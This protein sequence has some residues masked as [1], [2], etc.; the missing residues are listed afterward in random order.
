MKSLL[1]VS[2]GHRSASGQGE[3]QRRLQNGP[4]SPPPVAPVALTGRGGDLDVIRAFLAEVPARGRALLLSG[5]LG[6]GKSALLDAADEAASAAGVRILRAAGTESEEVPFSGLNQILLPLRSEFW[7]L[8][9]VHRNALKVALGLAEGPP[10]DQLVVSNAALTLL[11]EAAAVRRL[12]MIVDDLP[13][14]DQ[15]S[16]LV[17]GF[18]IRRLTGSRVWFLAAARSGMSSFAERDM[19]GHEVRPLDD[20]AA[21]VLVAARF[22]DLAPQVRRRVVAEAQGNPLALLELPTALSDRQRSGLAALRAVLPLSPALRALFASRVTVLPAATRYL[23]LLAVLEGTGRLSVLQ[24]AAAQRCE[25]DALTQAEQA[26]LVYVGQDTGRVAFR[27]PL[28]RSA[29]MELSASSDV[30]RAHRALAAQLADQPGRR[31]WHL[32]EAAVG[33]DEHVAGLLDK[34]ARQMLGRGAGADAV[35]ALMRAAQ[36]SPPGSGRSLRLAEAAYLG[37]TVT[38]DLPQVARLLAEERG[39]T[40]A[41]GGSRHAAVAHAH[42]LLN[43]DGDIDSVHR[44]LAGVLKAAPGTSDTALVAGPSDTCDTT[45]VAVLQTLL[46]VCSWGGR[47]ELW[48]SFDAAMAK[49]G[50]DVAPGLRL[51]ARTYA[52]PARSAPSALDQLDAAIDDL[53]GETD[54]WRALTLSAAASRTDRLA[55][56]RESLQRVVRDS[57]DGGA[58]LPA[59]TALTLLCFDSFARGG[60]D[61]AQRQ[62]QECLRACQ[63]HGYPSR[64]WMAREGLAILAAARGDH[65]TV[66]ALTSDMMQWALPRGIGQAQMAAHHAGSLAALGQLDFEEAYR[67]AAAISPPGILAPGVPHALSVAMD[68]VE[69]AVRTGR[70]HE[71]AAHVTAMREAGIARISPRLAMLAHASAAMIAPEP[72]ATQLFEQALGVPGAG[73][74]PF[75]FAR[76]QLAYGEHLHRIR[77]TALARVHLG[78]A[79]AT[80]RTLGARP[81]TDRAGNE[82]RATGLAT[83][84][85]E[86]AGSVTLTAQEHEIATLAAGGLT[87]KQIGQ[88]LYLSHRTVGCHLSRLYT[89]L[90]ISTRAALRDALTAMDPGPNPRLSAGSGPPKLRSA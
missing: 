25:I 88:R 18:V 85:A 65:E 32:A 38:G 69:A 27:H 67:E 29:V 31:A 14:V 20:G 51:F 68:L 87:N 22:P 30:R 52:D 10:C 72:Q 58:A 42:V 54:Q 9:A 21:A 5:E 39:G 16:A 80:F 26:G 7:R 56:C 13:W 76:V 19:P 41:P 43:T 11:C 33:P 17:L 23:L 55:G 74:W 40:P 73:R 49:L 1:E 15:A 37:A 83:A 57:Q 53:P 36:L 81:W 84:R 8:S 59:I 90:G 24:A 47:P 70:H 61:D 4:D 77:T 3:D 2:Y 48:E 50:P 66:R 28:I 75:E 60:W 12:L 35:T 79:L 78:A 89:K 6:V 44:L 82:L 71:A 86:S 46:M 64:A 63:A 62:A 45:L 34:A